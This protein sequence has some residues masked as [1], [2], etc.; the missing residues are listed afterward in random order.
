MTNRLAA[1]AAVT[2]VLAATAGCNEVDDPGQAQNVVLVTGITV[3]GA[4]VALVEDTIANITYSL[5]PRGGNLADPA[6]TFFHDVT[7]TSYSVAFEPAVIPSGTGAIST[8]YCIAG[9]TCTVS[10]VLVPVG[11]KPGAGTTVIAR[12]S[13]EGRDVNDNPV[14]FDAVV[15][16]TFTP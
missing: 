9:S 13:V 16:I 7:L 12:L 15:P 11:S 14:N 4:S 6:T 1:L 3:T 2:L 10:L 8:G 5:N